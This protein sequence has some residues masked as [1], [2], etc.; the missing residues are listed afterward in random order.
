MK[1]SFLSHV[2]STIFAPHKMK[3]LPVGKKRNKTKRAF[4]KETLGTGVETVRTSFLRDSA[5]VFP[6][7]YLEV[8]IVGDKTEEQA[9][10]DM[11]IRSG[12]RRADKPENADLVVFTGGVD[13]N[14]ALYG[15]ERH[16]CTDVP[17]RERD[18]TDIAIY[19]ICLELGIPM[20]G[21]CRGMQLLHVLAGGKLYQDVDGHYGDHYMTLA[22]DNRVL[23]KISSVHHQMCMPNDDIGMEILAYTHKSSERRLNIT[24]V[25]NGCNRDIEAAW[26]PE[27]GAF[28]VQGHPEYAGY[29]AFTYWCLKRIE[30]FFIYNP[31]FDL[32]DRYRRMQ[33]TLL[34][35]RKKQR[36]EKLHEATKELN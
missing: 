11:F 29:A 6:D 23:N 8:Y 5:L 22:R 20:F 12:C 19:Q 26:Y 34:A 30:E 7:L 18:Q 2:I 13:V 28:A 4:T 21:V 31:E 27:I 10:A 36:L 14:P 33:P 3:E 17:D 35:A 24:S 9:F 16:S 32:I 1:F 15:E 25:E